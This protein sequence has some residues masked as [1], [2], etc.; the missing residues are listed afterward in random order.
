MDNYKD[1]T[2]Y[3]HQHF[4]DSYNIGWDGCEKNLDINDSFMDNLLIYFETPFNKVRNGNYKILDFHGKQYTLGLS[5][6]RVL[7]EDERT[8]YAA[9]DMILHNILNNNYVPPK[10]F[11]EAVINGAK[12][13]TDAYKEYIL[14]YNEA[15]LWGKNKDYIEIVDYLVDLIENNPVDFK[16]VINANKDYLDIVT[17]KGSLLNYCILKG[18]IDLSLYL[19]DAGININN[20]SGIEILSAINTGQ[21][22]LITILLRNNINVNVSNMK[23]NPIFI[24]IRKG[25]LKLTKLLIDKTEFC[26]KY[27]NEFYQDMD[28]IKFSKLCNKNEIYEFLIHYTG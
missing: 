15:H 28:M 18:K 23:N 22:E 9:P 10:G 13:N 5:E 6:I 2:Y 11:M 1:F 8:C 19:I 24:A 20:F 12:P 25:D 26:I 17:L 27:N 16:K 4:E 21:E 7:S 14:R 3:S